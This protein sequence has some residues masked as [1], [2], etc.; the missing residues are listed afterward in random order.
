MHRFLPGLVAAGL[1]S[2]GILAVLAMSIRI[3]LSR[4]DVPFPQPRQLDSRWVVQTAAAPPENQPP[5]RADFS[6]TVVIEPATKAVLANASTPSGAADKFVNPRVK[7]GQVKWHP[8]LADACKAAERSGKPVLL[9][10][11]MGKLDEQFC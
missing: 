4:L 9:F 5:A 2:V 6:K 10:Q 1:A 7:P 11:M 8:T 3:G